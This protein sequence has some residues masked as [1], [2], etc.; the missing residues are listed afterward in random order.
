MNLKNWLDSAGK[1]Q[2][3]LAEQLKENV[4]TVNNWATGRAK[5]PKRHEET[6]KSFGFQQNAKKNFPAEV[7]ANTGVVVEAEHIAEAWS[8]LCHAAAV[9]KVDVRLMDETRFGFLLGWVAQEIA[10]KG[11]GNET[12]LRLHHRARTLMK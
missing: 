5:I 7:S 4:R 1:T 10:W 2:V 11:N 9:E 12:R 8:I 6:L 3:W